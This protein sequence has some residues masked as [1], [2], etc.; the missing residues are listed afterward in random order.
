MVWQFSGAS[1]GDDGYRAAT[2]GHPSSA[3]NPGAL[4]GQYVKRVQTTVGVTSQAQYNIGTNLCYND[5]PYLG[6]QT[7]LTTRTGGMPAGGSDVEWWT[8]TSAFMDVYFTMAAD[9]GAKHLSVA[10]AAA[11]QPTRER[12]FW[13][14]LQNQANA[15]PVTGQIGIPFCP[16]ASR[17]FDGGQAYAF[18]PANPV[19]TES[20]LRN[21]MTRWIYSN[22][23]SQEMYGYPCGWGYEVANSSLGAL[24]GLRGM[25]SA[26][27]AE[28]AHDIQ[29]GTEAG[30]I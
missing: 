20:D 4:F 8:V 25:S 6:G 5:L 24:M 26:K 11:L 29:L 14:L 23:Y 12:V 18:E 27:R 19:A 13:Q 2:I 15:E 16:P 7:N 1:I 22:T 30:P 17:G 3:N 28:F 9:A 10:D 21:D